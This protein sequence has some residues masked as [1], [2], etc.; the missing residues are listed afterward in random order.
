[1][2]ERIQGLSIE[3]GL[4]TIKIDSGLGELKRKLSVVNSEMKSNMSALDRGEKSVAKY[5]TQI[6]G[7]TRKLD[8]QK[9]ALA[10]AKNEY[11]RM[12]EVHGEGSRQADLAAAAYNRQVAAV[13]NLERN[14]EG[15]TDELEQMQEQQRVAESG[16]TR[17]GDSMQGVGDK[18][19]A[20]GGKM[21]D[22][23]KSLSM[24]VTAPLVGFAAIAA[25][26]GIDFD[27]SMAKVQAVS[28]ATGQ[29]LDK[30]R[31]KAKEMGAKTKFSASESAEALNYMA[32]AGWKTTDMLDGLEGVMNLAAA[33]G[34]D[35]GIV[36]DIVTDGLTAF[37]LTAEDSGRFADVLAAASANAN[38]NVGMLGKSFEYAAPVAG[39][40]GYSVED[41]AVALGLMANA[42]IKADKGG[43]ALRSMLTNLV[44]PN[45]RMTAIM[46]ELNISLT[47]SSGNMKDLDEI[48]GDLRVGFGGLTEDQQASYAAMLFGK[49]AMSGALAVINASEAD[50][51]KLTKAVNG[52]TGAAKEMAG[53]MEGKLGGTIREI[54][55][56]LEGFAISMYEQ[57]LPTLEKAADK[58][59]GFVGWLND[60]SPAAKKTALMVGAFAAAI[61]PVLIGLGTLAISLG[62][63][64]G[65][66][67][68]ASSAIAIM[69]T[70]VAAATPLIGGLATVFTV[71]TGPIGLG[72][73]AIAGITVGIVA[74]VNHMKKDAIPEIDRFGGG[75]SKATKEALGGFFE[76]S[77]GASQQLSDLTINSTKITADMANELATKYR[78]MNGEILNGMKTRH[79][80][81]IKDMEHFFLNS[82]ALTSEQEEE[83]VRKQKVRNQA[84]ETDQKGYEER[85]SAI[86][87][88]ASEGKRELTQNEKDQINAIQ[89]SMNENAVKYLTDNERDQKVILENMKNQAGDLSARQ[90][91]EVVKNSAKSRDKVI[92]DADTQLKETIG[93]AIQQRDEMGTISAEEADA[94][95]RE[96][97]KKRDESVGHAKSAHKEVV[98]EAKLQAKEHV[99]EVDWETGEIKSKW[100]IYKT[101]VGKRVKESGEGIKKDF[102]DMWTKVK[103]DTS[104][105][106]KKTKD[107][108]NALTTSVK[109]YVGDMATKGVERYTKF[110]NDMDVVGGAI[111]TTATKKW[112]ETKTN[113]V[114]SVTGIAVDG[115]KKYEEMKKGVL[116][117]TD[118][119]KSSVSTKWG[120]VKT[121]ITDTLDKTKTKASQIFT[122]IVGGATA[123]PGRMKTG[124]LSMADSVVQGIKTIGQKMANQFGRIING[125]IGGLNT[126]TG[127]L[128]IKSKVST[129]TVPQFAN[130]TDGHAG[131]LMVVGDKHGRELVELPNG[132]TFLSPD[133]DTLLNAPKGTRVIPNKI[134]EKYLAGD[135]PHFAK[136]T[137]VGGWLKDK[138]SSFAGAMSNIW[139]HVKNPAKL[140]DLM[141]L[142]SWD[143][144]G[145]GF[146]DVAKGA[147]SMVKSKAV[148]FIKN[149]FSKSEG[150]LGPKGG[151]PSPFRLTSRAGWRIHPIF[152]TRKFH[153]GDDWAAPEGTRIPSRGNGRVVHTGYHSALGNYVDVQ[154]G[155]YKLR[156]QHNLRNLVSKGDQVTNGQTL[157]LVGRTGDSTGPHLHFETRK[158]GAFVAP[159]DLGFASGGLIN[160]SGM[161]NLAE[162]GHPEFVIPTA[163]NRRTDAM[164]LL[165]LAGKAI[166]GGG[167]KR[168]N[169]LGSSGGGVFEQ[170]LGALIEQS[171]MQAEQ[172]ALL[173]KLVLKDT[174]LYV[175]GQELGRAVAPGASQ[176]M[177]D[178]TN[179]KNA[180]RGY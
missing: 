93:F 128:G 133:T 8:V 44:T 165:A 22:V 25:K 7:L 39:A 32:M 71:L 149:A 28:G 140:L 56:G 73:A 17:F 124:I 36:S 138:A 103:K 162:E 95:I 15:L 9:A 110:R 80:E 97:Q 104:D 87:K 18:M 111:K 92:K 120:Q 171:Q 132:K 14:I 116:D 102:S 90:A 57:M 34:E 83:I 109:D 156:Y 130:G 141:P 98:A 2:A 63:V 152:H 48:M 177:H 16:W 31:D 122:D 137:G 86:L 40:L 119:L 6:T 170:M 61:G 146:A 5:E 21:K 178:M 88:A 59:K 169:Q 76:L 72:I 42:G 126:I 106:V 60:L 142:P 4:D 84:K 13:N 85:I 101:E 157:G 45:K 147:L 113:V 115:L 175:D 10:N 166:S 38:T 3:L 54:K 65:F 51:N 117:K 123:L 49:E 23:G 33:S 151:F 148:E 131:G 100:E 167:N 176:G 19:K 41:T 174:N 47:D 172:I 99:D 135:I 68:S 70:G 168:P 134:T 154:S 94:I 11:D 81:Q 136:G 125:I 64:I 164:K 26:T 58:V 118:Q 158:N 12:V 180:I 62:S 43:T 77:D 74:L 69:G 112:D 55:S 108:W 179:I 107:D 160:R 127:K 159:K 105:G 24:Y 46:N 139:D 114:K 66:I 52:S 121:S 75:V 27:D 163:P 82:S 1:M 78:S 50:Y 173:T 150:Q 155:E 96:A 29:D 53:I 67:G 30:L 143:A 89:Q 144:G 153:Y 20:A 129:W 79:S 35:L 145:G 37:G 91:A 161:Y